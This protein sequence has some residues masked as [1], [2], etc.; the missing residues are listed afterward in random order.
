MALR[1]IDSHLSTRSTQRL[2][3]IQSRVVFSVAAFLLDVAAIL[4]AAAILGL[5]YNIAVYGETG[6]IAS[7]LT[8]GGLAALAYTL[9][10]VFREEYSVNSYLE[11][12]RN[13]SRTFFIWNTALLSLSC[14]AFF[15][16]ST[17]LFSRGA[18]IL[19]YVGGLVAVSGMAA[20]MRFAVMSL[21]ASGHI[22]SRRIMLVGSESEVSRVAADI[23][24]SPAGT[25]V[26]ATQVLPEA[27]GESSAAHAS[28]V[29]RSALESGVLKAR[30]IGVDDIVVLAD[31]SRIDLIHKIFDAFSV[32]PAAIHL[33][34]SN[35]AGPLF[36]GASLE[37][38]GRNG[39]VAHRSATWSIGGSCQADP[40]SNVGR[41]RTYSARSATWTYWTGN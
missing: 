34:A 18:L 1:N 23:T 26:V 17:E 33:G 32:V 36:R 27:D 15:T 4:C 22:A 30:A 7:H 38:V 10:F 14:V 40:R 11:G 8:V 5:V 41:D 2:P 24:R 37:P 20:L 31:W 9:P 6:I 21:I 29:M 35:S 25:C 13:F 12:H 3:A 16:K 19:L 39:V 28:N